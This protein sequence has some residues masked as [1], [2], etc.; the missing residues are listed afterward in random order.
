MQKAYQN[1]ISLESS[2]SLGFPSHTS[3]HC[4]KENAEGRPVGRTVYDSSSQQVVTPLKGI[5]PPN[6]VYMQQMLVKEGNEFL[7]GT[8]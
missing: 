6:L 8:F 3:T 1:L 4:N 7:P 2:A 5:L